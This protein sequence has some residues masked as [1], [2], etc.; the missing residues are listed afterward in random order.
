[1]AFKIIGKV[2]VG[3][4]I[5]V[6]MFINFASLVVIEIENFIKIATTSSEIDYSLNG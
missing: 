1:M 4:G 3:A 6:K 5:G 2:I